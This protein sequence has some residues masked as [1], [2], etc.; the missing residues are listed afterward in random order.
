MYDYGGDARIP[1]R[2][3]SRVDDVGK[4]AL[5]VPHPPS[6]EA[7]ILYGVEGSELNTAF[8]VAA[9]PQGGVAYNADVGLGLFGGLEEDRQQLL[10]N[11]GVSEVV[12]SELDLVSI[13]TEARGFGHDASIA[14]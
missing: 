12:C 10:D 6:Y 13:G 4:F 5:A 11:Q 2:Q 8:G 14:H 9:P 3:I 1:M 7:K